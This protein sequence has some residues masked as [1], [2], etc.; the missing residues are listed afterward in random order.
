MNPKCGEKGESKRTRAALSITFGPAPRLRAS[1]TLTVKQP[2][3]LGSSWRGMDAGGDAPERELRR[4]SSFAEVL[5]FVRTFGG[6]LRQAP[7]PAER[8]EQALLTPAQHEFPRW[9]YGLA[10]SLSRAPPSYADKEE[11]LDPDPDVL[12]EHTL[13]QRVAALYAE[14]PEDSPLKGGRSW[15]DLTAV[16]RVRPRRPPAACASTAVAPRICRAAA[17]CSASLPTHHSPAGSRAR[18]SSSARSVCGASRSSQ[19]SLPATWRRPTCAPSPSAR[20]PQRDGFS[21]SA[22][23]TATCSGAQRSADPSG[24]ALT[25]RHTAAPAG[26]LPRPHVSPR[27]HRLTQLLTA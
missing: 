15:L 27:A 2:R 1:K 18:W 20:T 22:R 14:A 26:C 11:L 19:R 4:T 25:R 23:R 17:G 8:L 21:G 9:F 7:F 5:A 6:A 10:F 13:S 12:W 16:Q 24:R 3:V